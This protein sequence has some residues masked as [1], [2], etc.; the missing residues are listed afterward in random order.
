MI[1]TV[2]RQRGPMSGRREKKE[3]GIT[4]NPFDLHDR[5]TIGRSNLANNIH[6]LAVRNFSSLVPGLLRCQRS[7]SQID[8]R[9]HESI[10]RKGMSFVANKRDTPSSKVWVLFIGARPFF[11]RLHVIF[12]NAFSFTRGL[13]E[14][15][16]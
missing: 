11:F 1:W 9:S 5:T 7:L 4:W 16:T 10:E 15:N 8:F 6:R 13:L 2:P 14:W 3:I 12:R